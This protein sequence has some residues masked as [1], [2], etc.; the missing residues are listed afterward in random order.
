MAVAEQIP[1]KPYYRIGEVAGY[2]GL[3]THVLRYWE[4][5]FPQLKPVRAP[6][7]QRLFRRE[8]IQTLLTIYSLLYEQGFTIAG[9]RR[10]LE[11]T[12][13]PEAPPEQKPLFPMEPPP[14]E[15][16]DLRREIARE[17]K[18]ILKIISS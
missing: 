6:S 8:D 10:Y 18:A 11:N 14:G 15:N 5:V 12:P 9:A 17:L 2:L 16:Q 1:D 13:P 4:S 3:E 7:R